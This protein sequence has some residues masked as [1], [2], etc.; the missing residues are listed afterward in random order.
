MKKRSLP[1]TGLERSRSRLNE[2]VRLLDRA[3]IEAPIPLVI[4]DENNR[5]LR[6]SKGWTRFS[7]YTPEDIPTIGDWRQRAYGDREPVEHYTDE[8][9]RDDETVDDGEWVITAKDGSKRAWHFMV[10]PLGLL[11]G[12]RLLLVTAVDVT[13]R[14]R[15]EE[16]LL[17]TEE[18]LKQGVRVACLGIFDHDQLNETL[19]WSP[20]MRAICGWEPD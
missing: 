18:L 4:H 16:A 13:E 1:G 17:K 8:M 9:L 11:E 15:I 12:Q 3:I 19:Y 7:G 10:T 2:I 14:K 5:I 6:V 20:E